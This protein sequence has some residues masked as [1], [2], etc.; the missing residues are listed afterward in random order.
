MTRTN[1][2]DRFHYKFHSTPLAF[3]HAKG[4]LK[5]VLT[6]LCFRWIN[7]LKLKHPH[8]HNQNDPEIDNKHRIKMDRSQ[9]VS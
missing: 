7:F 5:F 2:T 8:F 6:K 1:K 9:K 3:Q 4:N